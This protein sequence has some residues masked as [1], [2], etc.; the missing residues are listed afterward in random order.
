MTGSTARD[1]VFCDRRRYAGTVLFWQ[2]R[3]R[4]V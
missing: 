1:A 2:S 4:P 3:V